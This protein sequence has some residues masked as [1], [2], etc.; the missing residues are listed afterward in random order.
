MKNKKIKKKKVYPKRSCPECNKLMLY[1]KK[2][3]RYLC[4]A[5]DYI[6]EVC[7]MKY[8]EV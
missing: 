4:L 2:G 3:K 7:P 8:K 6:G 5:C 1:S